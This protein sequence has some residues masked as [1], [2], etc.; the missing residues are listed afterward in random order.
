MH[1]NMASVLCAATPTP[2][3][4]TSAPVT[5]VPVTPIPTPLPTPAPTY[6]PCNAAVGIAN[7]YDAPCSTLTSDVGATCQP[8]CYSGYQ[9][10]YTISGLRS[11]TY[12]VLGNTAV[13]SETVCSVSAPAGGQ[14][15]TCSS[16][17]SSQ[18]SC[19]PTCSTNFW[20]HGSTTAS[21]LR[22]TLSAFYC[23]GVTSSSPSNTPSS[24]GSS[25]TISG[26]GFSTGY[27]SYFGFQDGTPSVRLETTGY[28]FT[29]SWTT[30]T[31]LKC[32]QQALLSQ[33]PQL[34]AATVAATVSTAVS[35]LFSYDGTAPLVLCRPPLIL[36]YQVVRMQRRL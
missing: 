22:G 3:A 18:S 17:I 33:Q 10:A 30:N 12:G 29:S 23:L 13:C 32:H 8:T 11:C 1:Y 34:V 14:L 36:A 16:S 21:C 9:N 26:A 19:Q 6:A 5:P 25:L 35:R 2:P 15:G 7:G 28:C 31:A 27:T 4:G 20:R 24:G